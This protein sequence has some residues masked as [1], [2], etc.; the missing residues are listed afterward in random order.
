M[1]AAEALDQLGWVP[2]DDSEKTRY[3]IAKK[4]WDELVKLGEPA[5]GPLIETLED[6]DFNMCCGASIKEAMAV[7]EGAARTLGEIG[8]SS[9]LEALKQAQA[10][11]DVLIRR[12]IEKALK[13]I[14]SR[15]S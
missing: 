11:N 1:K 15:K 12:T 3:L 10:L 8:D 2:K 4:Q 5:V 6:E 9:A 7:R 14:E 13:R